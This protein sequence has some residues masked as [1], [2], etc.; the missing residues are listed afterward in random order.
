MKGYIVSFSAILLLSSMLLFSMF[1]SE[2]VNSR[3]YSGNEIKKYSKIEF[4]KDDLGFDINKIL[5]TSIEVQKEGNLGIVFREQIPADFNKMQRIVKLKEFIESSYSAIN[6]SE[7]GLDIGRMNKII[8]IRFSNNLEYDYNFDS[9]KN[10]VV[11]Y[12]TNGNTDIGL[13][14]LNLNVSGSSVYVSDFLFPPNPDVTVNFNYVD[15]NALNEKHETLLVNSGLDYPI[16]I[17]F[18]DDAEDIIEIHLGSFDAKTNAVK[19]WNRTLNE[20]KISLGLKTVMPAIDFNSGFKAFVVMD[21]NYMQTDINSDSL[22][23]LKQ[24]S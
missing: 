16:T 21:L 1:Y 4:I 14:D 9:G 19:V 24:F 11:F 5:G 15:G 12:S 3:N 18:S 10:S 23:E 17:R 8:P 7:I 6:N 20:N 2:N 22:I 13:M